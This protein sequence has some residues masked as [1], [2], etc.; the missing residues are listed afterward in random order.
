MVLVEGQ[1]DDATGTVR[2]RDPL[3]VLFSDDHSESVGHDASE[4]VVRQNGASGVDAA[5]ARAGAKRVRYRNMM[6][7]KR[8]KEQ[9]SI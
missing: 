7:M 5:L 3:I 6:K 4:G 9:T 1:H 2:I 8:R